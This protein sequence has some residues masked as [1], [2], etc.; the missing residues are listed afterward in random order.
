MK[1]LLSVLLAVLML[2]S[3]ATIAMAEGET[4]E[5]TKWNMSIPNGG[6]FSLTKVYTNHEYA[7]NETFSFEI[8][9]ED[10]NVP[11][12]S[13]STLPS[14]MD[15][16]LSS[17]ITVQLPT[18]N[19]VGTYEYE[20][21]EVAPESTTMGVT[22]DTTPRTLIVYVENNDG[23]NKDQQKFKCQVALKKG[24]VKDDTFT[25]VYNQGTLEITK[26]VTSA[27]DADKTKDY[28]F[29][30]TLGNVNEV[31]YT[32]VV[33]NANGTPVEGVAN[34]TI[35]GTYEVSFTLKDGQT[36]K[37]E[38]LPA[39]ATYTVTEDSP[40]K[41]PAHDGSVSV[42]YDNDAEKE[43]AT[44]TITADKTSHATIDNTFSYTGDL[45]VK[46][47]V[48]G[49]LGDEGKWFSFTVTGIN[50]SV[51][52]EKN[53][54]VRNA[55]MSDNGFT[56]EM[57]HGGEIIFK[58]LPYGTEYTVTEIAD[59]YE[60]SHEFKQ[61]FRKD[62][63]KYT[64]DAYATAED[65]KID[66]AKEV[67]TFTNKNEQT[68]ETGVSLDTLPYVLVLALAGAGLVLMIARKRRVED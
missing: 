11:M 23:D 52:V 5:N 33:V 24:N 7:P 68:I 3:M 58:E 18:Y 34:V 10:K 16:V 59:G 1:K 26:N 47:V 27:V 61:Y 28:R 12:P 15:G 67:Y 8:T 9:S 51:T 17:T 22:Y 65:G 43:A 20:M 57:Q 46:K 13:V 50:S 32:G 40:S 48:T 45:V 30:I 4:T 14:N 44:G 6:E 21:K 38:H 41:D 63:D 35:H 53:D 2:L 62:M 49:N 37:I 64:E 60:P 36:L 25:N 66:H 29:K 54:K 19:K 42:K 55:G 56:F 39:G 31:D